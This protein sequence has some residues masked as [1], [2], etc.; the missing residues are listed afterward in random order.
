MMSFH[1]SNFQATGSI[2]TL[3]LNAASQNVLKTIGLSQTEIE[4]F[5]HSIT[6]VPCT[7]T[8]DVAKILGIEG[9]EPVLGCSRRVDKHYAYD[10]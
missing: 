3:L 10:Y 8:Q 2:K 9:N 7:T 4:H 6:P 5:Q 1:R